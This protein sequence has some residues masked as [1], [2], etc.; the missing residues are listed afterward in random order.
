MQSEAEIK[1]AE[2][3]PP[4]DEEFQILSRCSRERVYLRINSNSATHTE[5]QDRDH[6]HGG[7]SR[8]S[9]NSS[10]QDDSTD[11]LTQALDMIMDRSGDFH[12]PSHESFLNKPPICKAVELGEYST[13]RSLLDA[14]FDISSKDSDGN[15]PLHL[16]ISL[17]LY[18]IMQLLLSRNCPL[19]T[20]NTIGYTPLHMA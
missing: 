3:N 4:G 18:E 1:M 10:L 9:L 8:G 16:A 11:E 5:D 20:C 14:G 7:Q 17:K 2:E 19:D 12:D 6:E 15:S 13:V